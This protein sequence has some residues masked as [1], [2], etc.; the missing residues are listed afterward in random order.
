[1]EKLKKLLSYKEDYTDEWGFGWGYYWIN[2]LLIEQLFESFQD[3][4]F[5]KFIEEIKTLAN[6]S[7]HSVPMIKL[8][9]LIEE[10]Q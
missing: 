6:D 9:K 2:P 4:R 3:K 5:E 8:N 10:Y 7:S 1:M